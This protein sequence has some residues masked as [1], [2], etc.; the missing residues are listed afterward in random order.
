MITPI[1]A[2][3]RAAPRT[4]DLER[5]ERI[6]DDAIV[7]GFT[8]GNK[9]ITIDASIFPSYAARKAIT[10]KYNIFGW[11][12]KYVSDQRDGDYLIFKKHPNP[13]YSPGH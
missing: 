10:S 2:Q 1:E 9:E 11:D 7:L 4:A 8:L 3:Q 5:L 12:V 13:S 6:I